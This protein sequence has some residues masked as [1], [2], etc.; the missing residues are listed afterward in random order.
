MAESVF[1]VLRCSTLPQ[2]SCQLQRSYNPSYIGFGSCLYYTK[3]PMGL[4]NAPNIMK[5]KNLV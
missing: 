3:N 5:A 4:A 2:D 1:T